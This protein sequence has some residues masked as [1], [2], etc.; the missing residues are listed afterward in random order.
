[1]LTTTWAKIVF[2]N[3]EK[4]QQCLSLG[5]YFLLAEGYTPA[6]NVTVGQAHAPEQCALAGQVQI[7]VRV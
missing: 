5:E 6:K 1:V 2:L 3:E 7:S 4:I